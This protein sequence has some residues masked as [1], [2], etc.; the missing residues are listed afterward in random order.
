MC[1]ME[2]EKEI[3]QDEGRRAQDHLQEVTDSHIQMM[4]MM[5]EKKEAEVMEVHEASPEL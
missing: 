3:S 2:R 1:T 5:G 4:D